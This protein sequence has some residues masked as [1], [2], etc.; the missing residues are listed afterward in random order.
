MDDLK[1]NFDL[2]RQGIKRK[3][4]D[5]KESRLKVRAALSAVFCSVGATTNTI[6]DFHFKKDTL[7]LKTNNKS[8]ANEIFLR[9]SQLKDE[10]KD[11]K[12]IKNIVIK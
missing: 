6:S 3:E 7:V 10:I 4:E 11:N 12:K 1:L 2:L 9:K 8:I 5:D